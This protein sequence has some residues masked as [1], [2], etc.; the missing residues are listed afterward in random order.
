MGCIALLTVH[1]S[2]SAR[3]IR[4]CQ[5]IFNYKRDQINQGHQTCLYNHSDNSFAQCCLDLFCVLKTSKYSIHRFL[6]ADWSDRWLNNFCV[7]IKDRPTNFVCKY[8]CTQTLYEV[9]LVGPVN[10]MKMTNDRFVSFRGVPL[11]VVTLHTSRRATHLF[12]AMLNFIMW[13]VSCAQFNILLRY[14]VKMLNLVKMIY[15]AT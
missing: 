9:E 7:G 15:K 1:W 11:S 3:A 12:T 8:N 14:A 13:F 2:I 4:C 6:Y 10:F 5:H